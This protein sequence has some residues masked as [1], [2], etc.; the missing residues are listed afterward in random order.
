VSSVA[1]TVPGLPAPKGSR[2]TGHRKDGSI[3]TRE[4]SKAA[5]P[6][7][8]AVA[9]IARTRR[10]AGRTLLPPYAVALEF[11]MPCGQRPKYDWPTR[12]GDLDKL[13]RA[14]LDGLTAADLLVD[15]RHVVSL[16]A[17]KGWAPRP[18]AEGV[19]VTVEETLPDVAERHVVATATGPEAQRC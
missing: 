6:W 10:P 19:H 17:E 14:V 1:F 11:S 8:E 7:S 16:V 13:V 2:S 12:D 15:D 5:G 9:L 3:Y 4:S 18:G